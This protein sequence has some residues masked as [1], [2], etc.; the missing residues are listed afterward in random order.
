MINSHKNNATDRSSF[1]PRS[2]SPMIG[3]TK[4]N[5]ISESI[6][7]ELLNNAYIL[8]KFTNMEMTV[9][10]TASN[11][12][13][14]SDDQRANFFHK[15]ILLEKQRRADLLRIEQLER[16]VKDLADQL[17][18]MKEMNKN[19]L[20][21]KGFGGGEVHALY[22]DLFITDMK[23]QMNDMN[24]DIS[25]FRSQKEQIR[26]EFESVKKENGQLH[27]T[28]KRYRTMLT[29]ALKKPQNTSEIGD[30]SSAYSGFISESGT[31][32][33][34][35]ESSKKRVSADNLQPPQRLA[36]N[37]LSY[38]KVE[39]LNLVLI[40]L[41]NCTNFNQL[42]KIITRAAKGLTKSQRVSVFVISTKARDQY[43][44]SFAG[45]ADFIG[46]VR[47]GNL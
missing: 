34:I 44:K 21:E 26:K 22:Q 27:A 20:E 12:S 1:R 31:V 6:P 11:E 40:Q 9:P 16:Q 28:V 29:N 2:L 39:K 13:K 42:C 46:K 7:A 47:L 32:G 15:M 38:N 17:N 35:S 14:A 45:S 25:K 4:K 43:T 18:T 24:N 36:L 3:L 19:L 33:K 5:L 37:S 41:N 30:S 23:Q 8:P 10:Q